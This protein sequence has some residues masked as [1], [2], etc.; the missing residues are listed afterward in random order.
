[1]EEQTKLPESGT[2]D[3]REA[4]GLI[5]PRYD[6]VVWS[7]ILPNLWMG[8]THYADRV[9]LDYDTPFVTT[10]NFD[11]AITMYGYANPADWYVAEYRYPIL[12]S[13]D[14]DFDLSVIRNLV[15]T[16]YKDWKSGKRVL[17]RCQAGLNRSGLITALVLM[18][19]GF[20]ADE[21][22]NL[23]RT[24]RDPMCLYNET[25]VAWLNRQDAEDWLPDSE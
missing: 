7:E 17:I 13:E 23:I 21:A 20:T 2:A 12:D 1:M 16:A 3:F 24:T 10:E 8:G 11:T 18:M 5:D 14:V 25:F 9:G 22:I 15:K 19:D 4:V 6:L